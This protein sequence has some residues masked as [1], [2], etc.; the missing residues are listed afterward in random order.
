MRQWHRT[1]FWLSGV[2]TG[3]PII[4]TWRWK[5]SVKELVMVWYDMMCTDCSWVSNRW[6]W[7]VNLYK[8]R[9]EIAQKGKQ[10]THTHTHTHTHSHR[11]T[12]THTHTQT[13]THTHTHTPTQK[14]T[15]THTHTPHTPTHTHT[16]TLT[17]T[18]THTHTHPHTH[19][20]TP[21]PTHTHHKKFKEYVDNIHWNEERSKSS[22]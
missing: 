13:Q 9:K 21:T 6:Q 16:H 5:Q 20:D 22:E 7:S 4:L 8:D 12:H 17:H 19:T 10:Y 2:H 1:R 3:S 14:H 11:H 15:H 18:H